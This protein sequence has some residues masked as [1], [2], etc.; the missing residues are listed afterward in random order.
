ML[1]GLNNC[2]HSLFGC[3]SLRYRSSLLPGKVRERNSL[4]IPWLERM[5]LSLTASESSCCQ[6]T[7]SFHNLSVVPE[8]ERVVIKT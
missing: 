1:F 5:R 8:E 3:F 2:H 6:I 4:N 7:P